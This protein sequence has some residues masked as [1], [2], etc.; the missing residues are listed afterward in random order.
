MKTVIFRVCFSFCFKTFLLKKSKVCVFVMSGI[1]FMFCVHYFFVNWVSH[2]TDISITRII[3]S[4]LLQK[5]VYVPII[6]KQ[7][8]F[9]S[10]NYDINCDRFTNL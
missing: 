6:R 8:H 10:H 2:I 9:Y 7:I 1:S 4:S 3:K 5:N